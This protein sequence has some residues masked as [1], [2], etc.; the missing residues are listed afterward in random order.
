MCAGTY[1]E[2]GVVLCQCWLG[3]KAA[4]V[5]GRS[6]AQGEG[7]ELLLI[8]ARSAAAAVALAAQVGDSPPDWL[9][10]LCSSHCWEALEEQ[11]EGR[12]CTDQATAVARVHNRGQE[13]HGAVAGDWLCQ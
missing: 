4:Q 8:P 13:R 11:G 2:H 7:L 5:A 3:S 1:A 9:L 10:S 6:T 12:G